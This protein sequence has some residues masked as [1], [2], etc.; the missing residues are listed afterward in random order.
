MAIGDKWSRPTTACRHF[1][2]DRRR[3]LLEDYLNLVKTQ[4]REMGE[5]EME[6]ALAGRWDCDIR[7][8]QRNLKL[9]KAEADEERVKAAKKVVS[10]PLQEL[11]EEAYAQCKKGDHTWCGDSRFNGLSYRCEPSYEVGYFG[12]EAEHFTKTCYF[13]GYSQSEFKF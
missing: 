12:I 10:S 6:E 2:A 11:L 7:T 8:I 1:T 4:A 5:R 9:A 13:C 3:L